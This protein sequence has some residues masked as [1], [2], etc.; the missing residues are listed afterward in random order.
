MIL[1][2]SLSN[3]DVPRNGAE[4]S[5]FKKLTLIFGLLAILASITGLIGNISDTIIISSVCQGCKTLAL[6]AAL[7]WIFFGAVLVYISIKPL[8]RFFFFLLRAVLLII[9]CTEFIDI[10]LILQ[11]AHFIIESWFVTTGSM[12]FGPLSSP[13]S[14]V[15]SGLIIIAAVGM[16]FC[17]DPAFLSS[18]RQKSREITAGS[19][20]HHQPH[21][22]HPGLKLPV[23]ISTS[24]W[25]TGHSHCGFLS[26]A[27]FIGFGLIAAA[28]PATAP[29]CYFMEIPFGRGSHGP[30]SLSRLSSPFV[31]LFFFLSFLRGFLFPMWS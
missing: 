29:A 6:S 30:L 22:F 17:I 24:L 2:P 25:H 12:I 28:G 5:L 15:A 19:R 16:F 7:T 4:A 31:K 11:G 23:W 27:F 3:T 14:P 8:R 9:A 1:P 26:S 10:I 18:Q 20:D 21:R 13:I